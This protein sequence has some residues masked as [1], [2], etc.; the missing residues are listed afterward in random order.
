M[1]MK[2]IRHGANRAGFKDWP[3]YDNKPGKDEPNIA[4]CAQLDPDWVKEPPPRTD[5]KSKTPPGEK[6]TEK[7]R[8]LRLRKDITGKTS[9]P[10]LT[11]KTCPKQLEQNEEIDFEIAVALYKEDIKQD[12][13]NYKAQEYVAPKWVQEAFR[14]DTSANAS[15]P[16]NQQ[17]GGSSSSWEGPISD[18]QAA[19]V[20]DYLLTEQE[21]AAYFPKRKM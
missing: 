18:T 13:A 2:L 12:I 19:A 21:T 16:S 9:I 4:R 3:T 10:R 1:T 20:S 8:D 5:E 17:R 11:R 14:T 7:I 15:A 6:I